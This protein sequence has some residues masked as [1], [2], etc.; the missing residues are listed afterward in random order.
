MANLNDREN[1]SGTDENLTNRASRPTN[2]NVSP[3]GNHVV[4]Q[5]PVSYQDGYVQGRSVEQHRNAINQEIRDNDNAGR[6]L[7]V[8]IIL[9][10]LVALTAGGLY[11]LNQRD[12][13]PAT[14][15]RTIIVPKAAPSPSP[16]PQVK[17]RIIERDRVVPVPQPAQPATVPNVNVT[18]PQQ[19]A[20]AQSAP[21]RPAPVQPAPAQSNT[22]TTTPRSS[23]QSSDSVPAAPSTNNANPEPNSSPA[24]TNAN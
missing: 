14:I 18:V 20:P 11:L 7:L 16:S 13:T 22:Q 1:Y 9:T 10:S 2:P 3:D 23:T 17:E 19:S 5:N 15:D 4:H 12:K 8:G 24:G 6:G 21:A